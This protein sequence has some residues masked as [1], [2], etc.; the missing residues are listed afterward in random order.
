MKLSIGDRVY[1]TGDMANQPAWLTVTSERSPDCY[2]MKEGGPNGGTFAGI[3]ARAIG[4]EY[5][6]HCNPRFVTE[7]AYIAFYDARMAELK[8]GR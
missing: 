4:T 2:D 5:H 7:A 8:R 1:Y 6:G 3:H